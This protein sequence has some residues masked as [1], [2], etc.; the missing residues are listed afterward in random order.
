VRPARANHRRD[1]GVVFLTLSY[2]ME[3]SEHLAHKYALLDLIAK[4]RRVVVL[5]NRTR[6]GAHRDGFQVRELRTQLLP[7]R[8][9][10]Q[11][12][13]LLGYRLRGFRRFYAH[14]NFSG[15]VASAIVAR[16][17]GGRSFTWD[18]GMP[19]YRKYWADEAGE[20]LKTRIK[21]AGTLAGLHVSVR[22]AHHLVT[23]TATMAAYYKEALG[24]PAQKC[25]VI[26][27][28]I[29]LDAMGPCDRS[30]ARQEL[31]ID[32]STRVILFLHRLWP[33]KGPQH[34]VPLALQLRKLLCTPFQMLVVGGGP[35][36]EILRKEVMAAGVEDLFRIEG[37]IPNSSAR[38]YYSAADVYLTP[39]EEEGF[40]HTLL[41]AM[42]CGCPFIAT[43]V[44][45]VPDVVSD[46]QKPFVLAPGDLQ[47]LAWR[48]AQ[49]A[50]DPHLRASLSREGRGWVRQY[51]IQ[52]A[53]EC[54]DRV[55]FG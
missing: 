44:G 20:S 52:A 38:L 36:L 26:P 48:T 17:T 47:G 21:H 55:V 50:S 23:G 5:A 22:A 27:N 18:C 34:L 14:Y 32:P 45:G 39:S 53:A 43:N 2:D 25:L 15:A 4:H 54:F 46:R 24:L 12:A 30:S 13:L 1:P 41:E 11:L 42:A 9:I 7:L 3:T 10:E 28:A 51:S 6:G 37:P 40:P 49:V 33:R 29:D 19:T 31:H 35:Y 16:L 8:F